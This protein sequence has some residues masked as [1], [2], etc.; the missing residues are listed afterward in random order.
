MNFVSWTINWE[1]FILSYAEKVSFDTAD[2]FGG[3]ND[4]K[5]PENDAKKKVKYMTLKDGL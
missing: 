2:V 4:V 1:V 3:I 5:D